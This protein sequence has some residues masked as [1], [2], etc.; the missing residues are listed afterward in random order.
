[1]AD[2]HLTDLR[3]ALERRGWRFEGELP[4]DD[5][6]ISAT[7]SFARS[8][9]PAQVLLIDFDGLDDTRTLPL[10]ES[11]GCSAR[12]TTSSLYFRRRGTNDPPARERWESELSNFVRAIG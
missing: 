11:Y 6:R 10:N 2:W 4:G 8:G 5:Y 3:A 7:W 12:G 1:M 9:T